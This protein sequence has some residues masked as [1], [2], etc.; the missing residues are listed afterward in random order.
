MIVHLQDVP[1]DAQPDRSLVLRRAITAEAELDLRRQRHIDA[2][3]QSHKAERALIASTTEKLR[4]CVEL[5]KIQPAAANPA[6][7]FPAAQSAA[8]IE[9]GR[10]RETPRHTGQDMGA[11][12]SPDATQRV[13]AGNP[14]GRPCRS[15]RAGYFA[16]AE[17]PKAMKGA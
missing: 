13:R 2:G 17:T 7:G 16:P 5:R 14:P 15:N 3:R 9:G 8:S 12:T 11:G 10:G 4:Q 1:L 6:P